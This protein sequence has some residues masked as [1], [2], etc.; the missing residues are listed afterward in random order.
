MKLQLKFIDDVDDT[1]FC[2]IEIDALELNEA[3]A[4]DLLKIFNRAKWMAED[5]LSF[6]SKNKINSTT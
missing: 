1:N 4:E 2:I 5:N 6:Y 3:T